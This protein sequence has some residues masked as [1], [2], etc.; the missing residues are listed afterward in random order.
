MPRN[1]TARLQL[2][3]SST[4]SP[5][6]LGTGEDQRDLALHVDSIVFDHAVSS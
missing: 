3:F 2:A 5:K 4:V 1:K 6:A